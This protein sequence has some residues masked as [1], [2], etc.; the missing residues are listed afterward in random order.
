MNINLNI[1]YKS[2]YFFTRSEYGSIHV[3]PSN[4]NVFLYFIP[5]LL[6]LSEYLS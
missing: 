1:N 2:E 4:F 6:V 5:V 3:P